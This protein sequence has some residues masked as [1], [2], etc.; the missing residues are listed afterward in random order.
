MNTDLEEDIHEHSENPR[1]PLRRNNTQYTELGHPSPNSF[2]RCLMYSSVAMI[3]L[4][5]SFLVT[6]TALVAPLTRKTSEIL[7][8]SQ[9]TL[10]DLEFVMPEIKEGLMI[11]KDFC[12]IP[13]FQ[14]YCYP[15]I[16]NSTF[17]L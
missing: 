17:S 2:Y 12:H 15:H 9:K 8:D 10:Q 3:F 11:L 14:N 16:K 7:D 1:I 5:L 6:I 4:S 13:E